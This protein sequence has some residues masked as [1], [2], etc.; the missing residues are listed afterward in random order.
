MANR[1]SGGHKEKVPPQ[2]KNFEPKVDETPALKANYEIRS[3]YLTDI[4]EKIAPKD[5]AETKKNIAQAK[6]TA[7]DDEL[8]KLQNLEMAIDAVQSFKARKDKRS[9]VENLAKRSLFELSVAAELASTY[10][11]DELNTAIFNLKEAAFALAQAEF[12]AE[13]EKQTKAHEEA[14]KKRLDKKRD[15]LMKMKVS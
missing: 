8:L 10:C 7:N 14:D 13:T 12:P 9:V 2:E 6:E 3:G 15:E 11:T 1:E 4:V 5:M